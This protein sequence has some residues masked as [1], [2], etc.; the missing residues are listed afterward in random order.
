M[1]YRDDR[2]A[3]L[4][5]NTA[6]ARENEQLRRELAE[7]RARPPRPPLGRRVAEIVRRL[8]RR[9]RGKN[10]DA[11]RA[12]MALAIAALVLAAIAA[13]RCAATATASAPSSSSSHT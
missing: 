2:D 1:S 9:L 10:P 5:R 13:P 4:A 11:L 6:L 8:R 12:R 3:M 7:E